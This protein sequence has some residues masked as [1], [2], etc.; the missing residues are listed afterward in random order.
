MG[1]FLKKSIGE[2]L[3]GRNSFVNVSGHSE[4]YLARRGLLC[5]VKSAPNH[6]EVPIAFSLYI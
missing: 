2:A 1:L 4:N 6:S 3:R 5:P